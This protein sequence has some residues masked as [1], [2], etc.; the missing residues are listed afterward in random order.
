MTRDTGHVTPDM[1]HVTCDMWNVTHGRGWTFS[2]NFRS[3][4]LMV[5]LYRWLEGLEETGQ[6]MNELM[7]NEGDFRTA[8]ATPGLLIPGLVLNMTGFVFIMTWI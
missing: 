7:S 3:L 6:W 1:W 4:A 5:W 8:L 2:Q